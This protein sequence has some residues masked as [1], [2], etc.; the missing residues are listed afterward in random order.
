M[1]LQPPGLSAR[2]RAGRGGAD[3][4]VIVLLLT[5]PCRTIKT[6]C[7]LRELVKDG[8]AAQH[9]SGRKHSWLVGVGA[10][11]WLSQRMQSDWRWFALPPHMKKVM[12]SNACGVYMSSLA[13]SHHSKHKCEVSAGVCVSANGC[14]SLCGPAMNRP[15]VQGFT[16]PSPY[17]CWERFHLTPATLSAGGSWFWMGGEG[18]LQTTRQAIG[19]LCCHVQSR[20]I[21]FLLQRVTSPGFV[22]CVG[23]DHT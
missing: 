8:K 19:P 10:P 3:D 23:R 16:L 13:S 22:L 18:A 1:L 4:D 20:P 21:R 12:G 7:S 5:C 9:A 15:P 11:C 17:D 2:G 14:R 6:S